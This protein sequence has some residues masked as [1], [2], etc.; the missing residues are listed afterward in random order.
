[1]WLRR[2]LLPFLLVQEDVVAPQGG[3]QG[4]GGGGRDGDGVG[5][6]ENFRRLGELKRH[7]ELVVLKGDQRQVVAGRATEPE[8]DGHEEALLL[9]GH[10]AVDEI[11]HVAVGGAVGGVVAVQV[12]VD[13]VPGGGQ[14][15]QLLAAQLEGDGLAQLLGGVEGGGGRE[16]LHDGLE[17]HVAQ[18]ITVAADDCRHLG[19][20]TDGAGER[21]RNRLDGKVGVPFEHHLEVRDLRASRQVDVLRTE[22]NELKQASSHDSITQRK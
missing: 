19:A 12:V 21:L 17:V 16:L 3:V 2:E 1:M 9:A 22:C 7:T 20:I 8:E 4:E 14:L 6:V 5:A 11:G 18:E 10:L 15:V 13:A